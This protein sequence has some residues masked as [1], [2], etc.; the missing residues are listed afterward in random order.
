MASNGNINNSQGTPSMGFLNSNEGTDSSGAIFGDEIQ[1]LDQALRLAARL[2]LG[3]MPGAEEQLCSLVK[4]VRR[5]AIREL[6]RGDGRKVESVRVERKLD[7]SV[8]IFFG[9]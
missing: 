3:L 9:I 5:L 6:D 8:T 2:H 4:N 1:D 7:G